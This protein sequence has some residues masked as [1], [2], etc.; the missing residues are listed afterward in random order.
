MP[1]AGAGG[2]PP[3]GP[4]GGLPQ[5]RVTNSSACSC[6]RQP[7]RRRRDDNRIH[8]HAQPGG[9]MGFEFD[10]CLV[11][12][13]VPPTTTWYFVRRRR[14]QRA[15]A[16]GS[17]APPPGSARGGRHGRNIG[18]DVTPPLQQ[19]AAS[20]LSSGAHTSKTRPSSAVEPRFVLLCFCLA[21]WLDNCSRSCRR[22]PRHNHLASSRTTTRSHDERRY[23]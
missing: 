9:V 21:A 1:A 3:R 10:C 13:C 17:A 16:A 6:C 22:C 11:D 5:Q 7:L 14:A 4:R 23:N 19:A 20:M 18:H 2:G 15:A 12:F 8:P